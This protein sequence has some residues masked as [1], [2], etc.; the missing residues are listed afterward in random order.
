MVGREV[1]KHAELRS[2]TMVAFVKFRIPDSRLRGQGRKS[3]GMSA[4]EGASLRDVG[5]TEDFL[6]QKMVIAVVI[7]AAL[8]SPACATEPATL[9]SL[10]EVCALTNAEASHAIPVAFEATVTYFRGYEK[11]LFVQDGDDAIYI[12]A[13]PNARLLPGDRVLVRGITHDSFH[14]YVEARSITV[15]RHQGLPRPLPVHFSELIRAQDDCRLVSLQAVVIAA[16]LAMSSDQRSTSL[17]MLADGGEIDAVVDS[18]DERALA[19][20]LGAKVEVTGAVSGRFD[21][22]M[23][24]TG[25]LLHIS[26]LADVKILRRANATPWALPVTPMDEILRGYHMDNL[27]Q[28]VRVRG[29]I[30]YYQPGSAVVLQSGAKS[31]WIETQT[32]VPLRIGDQAD[33]TGLPDVRDGFLTLTH[34]EIKDNLLEAPVTPRSATWR[35][36]T[37][38]HNVFDLVTIEGRVVMEVRE[39][40]QDEY[41]LASGDHRFSAIIRHPAAT[42]LIS[43]PLPRM[44]Q[45]PVGSTVRVTG[46]CILEDSNPFNAEVPFNILLRSFDDIS[47]VAGP[48][49]L[50]VR[51]LIHL[52]GLLFALL[53]AVGT[54]ALITERKLRRQNSSTA[55]IERRRSRI[56]ED[57]NGSRPLAE[58]IEQITGLVSFKLGG[59]P[60]WCQI[61]DGAQLGN[62]PKDLTTFR[63]VHEQ[64]LARSG[65]SLGTIHAAFHPLTKPHA[66]ESETLSA[67]AGMAT[68]AIETRRIYS[69]LRRRS[70]FDLLT[71]IHNRFSLERYLDE[72]I[73]QA[74][75]TASIF[76]LIYI[77][78]NNFKQVNDTYGHQVGDLY[79]REAAIR[80]KHQLRAVDMLARLG[81]DEFA[82]VVPQV[83]S[84]KEVAVVAQ[85]L[86][87]SFD[88]PYHFDGYV[89]HGSASIGFALYPEDGT[90]RD[91][92]LSA[93]DAAMYVAK[94]TRRH[95]E[96]LAD[97]PEHQGIK[98]S[99]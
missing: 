17:E 26:S 44:K 33:A 99:S 80:M 86:E 15:L 68:L 6:F 85:R 39:A 43:P 93:A 77:D 9:T 51:N 19:G 37:L 76:G 10:H 56:L 23:Q 11:T 87:R 40:A 29:T 75:Q 94:Q 72:Q 27:T 97:H 84:R 4:V 48:S 45:F 2:S 42:T 95:K 14:P 69:D 90:T 18:D 64:I 30:T 34:G 57:I 55:Y 59:A 5:R 78:L 31:L 20:L 98:K 66:N 53:F 28:R 96:K 47:V 25:I 35:Q 79:L 92:L 62:C 58:I 52:A 12:E 21:G 1:H 32:R 24:E 91:S 65:E 88:D 41:V 3:Q 83:H 46:I 13:T 71:D 22:K 8:L 38:S 63:V 61:S 36:L 50:S 16:D 74:R 60:S 49:L 82:V 54:W 67:A 81:G 70:E 89:L 7:T 73:E